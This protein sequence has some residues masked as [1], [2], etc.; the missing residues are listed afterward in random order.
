MT[1]DS[2]RYGNRLISLVRVSLTSMMAQVVVLAVSPTNAHTQRLPFDTGD[3]IRVARYDSS[4][5]GEWTTGRVYAATREYLLMGAGGAEPLVRFDDPVRIEVSRSGPSHKTE[6]MLIGLGIGAVAGATFLS[7]AFS[8]LDEPGSTAQ[9]RVVGAITF[10]GIGAL[11]GNFFG[12]K[13]HGT[14]WE[15]VTLVR[16]R[17]PA[18]PLTDPEPEPLRSLTGT[19]R[20]TRFEPTA[21]DFEAFFEEH[22]DSLLPVEGIWELDGVGSHI[23]IVRDE[24]LEGIEYLGYSVQTGS[25]QSALDGI[26]LMAISPVG[27][28]GSLWI[29]LPKGAAALTTTILT[30]SSA[31]RLA[32]AQLSVIPRYEG[33]FAPGTI[34]LNYAGGPPHRWDRVVPAP[35][36]DSSVVAPGVA[37]PATPLE[38]VVVEGRKL[39]NKL[40]DAGFYRRLDQGEGTF[41]TQEDIAEINPRT[42]S[43]ILRR[44]PGFIVSESG[45]VSAPRSR[46]C[47]G[48]SY[49][50]D[51]VHAEGS[52]LDTVLPSSI[53]G[54]EVYSGGATVP[55]QFRVYGQDATCGV[56]LIWMR[57]G[58]G[59][60]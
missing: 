46:R 35:V 3:T 26:L 38:A 11:L 21:E 37:D 58:P 47:T 5:L 15:E 16:G 51:G 42:T 40:W 7:S 45:H 30:S 17:I 55:M 50:I 29:Q 34:W 54:I 52:Y 12:G 57:D 31:L 22:A 59:E 1:P 8:Y 48:V 32:N 27:R 4:G 18:A 14:V 25:R 33:A 19:T 24:R 28:E 13:I 23:A 6:G 53:S 39:D 49:F 43:Q 9:S 41:I 44:L 2:M 60:H 36:P 56:V 10:G 20:W